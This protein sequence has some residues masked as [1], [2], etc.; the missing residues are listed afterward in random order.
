MD[1]AVIAPAPCNFYL[2]VDW[3]LNNAT[4]QQALGVA[5]N[6]SFDANVILQN[7][8]FPSAYYGQFALN[9][10]TGDA[11]RQDGLPNIKHLLANNV[12]VAFIFGDRDYRC[13]WTGGEATALAVNWTGQT[14]FLNA[15]YELLQGV[16]TPV[17]QGGLRAL[18]KQHGQFSFS[19]VMDAGHSV[20]AYAPE[21]VYQI[22]ARTV[23]GVDIVSGQTAVSSVYSTTGP[24]DSWGWRNELADQSPQGC[25]VEGQWTSTNPWDAVIGYGA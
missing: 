11:V 7:F 24:R 10:S 2:P 22:F 18:V 5:L 25:M 12:K 20:S 21:T 9:A 15:G 17:D 13:P 1:V 14:G 8:G 3:Y 4:V 6:Y 23:G 19:R 16:T